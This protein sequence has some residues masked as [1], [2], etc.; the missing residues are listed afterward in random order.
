MTFAYMTIHP[1]KMDGIPRPGS[2]RG[3]PTNEWD[4]DAYIHSCGTDGFLRLDGRCR[5]DRQLDDV[6]D[7]ILRL[8][9]I[10]SYAGFEIHCGEIRQSR[11]VAAYR[12]IDCAEG[13]ISYQQLPK[14]R[15]AQ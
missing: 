1:L 14:D 12:V 15:Y 4:T 9:G 2:R 5:L 6:M 8:R 11:C 13:G 7:Y 3:L 10:R